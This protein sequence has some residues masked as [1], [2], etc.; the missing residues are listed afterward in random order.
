MLLY[1]GE[2]AM[3]ALGAIRPDSTPL[4]CSRLRPA[5]RGYCGPDSGGRWKSPAMVGRYAEGTAAGRWPAI[6]LKDR[7]HA[8]QY[9]RFLDNQAY[10]GQN[11]SC[12]SVLVFGHAA[13]GRSKGVITQ[14][15]PQRPAGR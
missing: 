8:L 4:G 7:G 9:F 15:P 11:C 2:E 10:S 3:R 6:T 14:A 13:L 12:S 5:A 1:L